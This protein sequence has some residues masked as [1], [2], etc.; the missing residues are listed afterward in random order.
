MQ[1]G[2]FYFIAKVLGQSATPYLKE[3]GGDYFSFVLIGLAFSGYFMFALRSLSFGIR[4]EQM[5]GTLEAILLTPIKPETL[6]I[7]LLSWDFIF[8][9]INILIYLL[10]G[11]YFLGVKFPHIDVFAVFIITVLTIISFTSLGIFS[12][13]FIIIF[14]KGDPISWAISTFS[15]FF[16]GTYFPITILP[17]KLK[18]VSYFIPITYSLRSLRLALLQGYSLKALIFDIK[19]LSLFCVILF[20]LSV[21]AFKYAVRNVR[22]SG[23]LSHY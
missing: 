21:L 10:M 1:L 8:A 23:T 15:A 9:S 22:L 7:S 6:I 14:K 20:P 12:T 17:Q 4:E 11:Y 19:M 16:G 3:Y 2:M 13:A 5:T 18:A